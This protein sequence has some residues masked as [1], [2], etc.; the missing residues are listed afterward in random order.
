MLRSFRISLI[1]RRINP[2]IDDEP[3]RPSAKASF[4][5]TSGLF[6]RISHGRLFRPSLERTIH[7]VFFAHAPKT[8]LY[9]HVGHVGST[10]I[11][12]LL[13][14]WTAWLALREPRYCGK[15]DRTP[16]QQAMFDY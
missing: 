16:C 12:R 1:C 14:N 2:A 8:P 7:S 15:L 13:A 6:T 11:S 10:L 4:L 5:G 9:F 3:R